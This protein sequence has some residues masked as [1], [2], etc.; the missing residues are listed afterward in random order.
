MFM[1]RTLTGLCVAAAFGLVATLGAQSSTTG[2]TDQRSNDQRS[3]SY[4]ADARNDITLT[5]CL[6]KDARGNYMLSNATMG[7]ASS[8]TAGSTTAAPG[9]TTTAP[10]EARETRPGATAANWHLM[11]TAAELDRHIGHKITVTGS[12]GAAASSSARAGNTS[13]SNPSSS[14]PP[15]TEPSSRTET[16]TSGVS[17]SARAERDLNVKSVTM[18]SS[19]CP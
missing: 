1:K 18:V 19:S 12:E 10:G 8:S 2:S 17:G 15:S 13:T 16:G 5:G 4:R 6:S 7:P 11:G 9:A 3:N 14:N